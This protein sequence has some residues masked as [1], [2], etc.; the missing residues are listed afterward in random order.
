LKRNGTSRTSLELYLAEVS[1]YKLLSVDEEQELARRHRDQGDSRAAHRL[2]TS[3]LRFVVKVAYEYRSSS[4]TPSGGSGPTSRTTS[5]A[6]GR[7]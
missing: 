3:N 7:W 6:P 4:A 2:V 1:R 5:S